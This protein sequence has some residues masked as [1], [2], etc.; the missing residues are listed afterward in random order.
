MKEIKE[1]YTGLSTAL[2]KRV[3][4]AAWTGNIKPEK[5]AII[6]HINLFIT[7][8]LVTHNRLNLLFL[9]TTMELYRAP[10]RDHRRRL[11]TTSVKSRITPY[12]FTIENC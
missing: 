9:V 11:W 6:G 10:V 1:E 3:F 4:S 12:D 8:E 7:K 5:K 2:A